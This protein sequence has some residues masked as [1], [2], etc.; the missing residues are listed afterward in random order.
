MEGKSTTLANLGVV[1]AQSG[2]SVVLVDSDLRRPM[3]HKIFQV[4]NKMGLTSVL[5]QD[6]PILDG[7]LQETGVENLRV[8]TSGPLPPNPS[9][10]LGSQRMRHLIEQ[11]EKE[12]DV[13][14]F[15][16]FY[17]LVLQRLAQR[18][19][20]VDYLDYH[21]YGDY[22]DS[23]IMYDRMVDALQEFGLNNTKIWITE[24]GI[25]TIV[26][27]LEEKQAKDLV[28]QMVYPLTLGVKKVILE[29]LN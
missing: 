22:R 25:S 8:L 20:T 13:V 21:I 1:M 26:P 27:E 15:D 5:L 2:R 4:P 23:K 17:R 9:E 19:V 14:I 29:I 11:L 7:Q 16:N 18:N 12:G 10:L 3:L 6:D 28:K 24:T